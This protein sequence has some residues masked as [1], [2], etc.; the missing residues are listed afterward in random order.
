MWRCDHY[1]AINMNDIISKSYHTISHIS[2]NN[3]VNFHIIHTHKI[4]IMQRHRHAQDSTMGSSGRHWRP[5][6]L[7]DRYFVLSHL[8][9]LYSPSFLIQYFIILQCKL[10]FKYKDIFP[11]STCLRQLLS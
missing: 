6:Y 3:F 4:R 2:F 9:N 11:P 7:T 1:H 5:N 10:Q 8:L